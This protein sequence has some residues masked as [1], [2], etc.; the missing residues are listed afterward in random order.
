MTLGGWDVEHIM[1]DGKLTAHRLP[2]FASVIEGRI[3]YNGGQPPLL[4]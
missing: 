3:I 2:D 1:P 4:K